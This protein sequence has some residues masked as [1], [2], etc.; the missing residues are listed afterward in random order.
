MRKFEF[1]VKFHGNYFSGASLHDDVIKW[2]HFL[3]YWP[4]VLVTGEVPAHR[5][6]TRSS[7]VFF[8]LC[9]NGRLSKNREA[10]D[11]R[12]HGAHYVVT[13]MN[14]NSTLV[15][16]M[17]WHS[18]GRQAIVW[19]NDGRAQIKMWLTWWHKRKYKTHYEM[20]RVIAPE[21]GFLVYR[22]KMVTIIALL[23]VLHPVTVLVTKIC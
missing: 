11:L 8:D 14:T 19:T 1:I 15:Q 12:R 7:H 10:G 2:K 18:K 6:V 3:R 23:Y 17:V 21:K 5:P 20:N 13:V 22:I 16:I 9:L 4:S